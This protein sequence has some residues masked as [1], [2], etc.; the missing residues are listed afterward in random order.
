MTVDER[1]ALS[2]RLEEAADWLESDLP[3][4]VVAP[5]FLEGDV[6]L[7]ELDAYCVN[8]MREA[9]KALCPEVEQ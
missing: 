7:D 8:L 4:D 5:Q 1:I 2:D 9:S 3:V 6:K